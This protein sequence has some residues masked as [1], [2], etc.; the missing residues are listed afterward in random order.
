[1]SKINLPLGPLIVDIATT[2]LLAEDKEILSH[3]LV[4]GV[5]LFTRNFDNKEQ[6]THLVSQ[7][8]SL[9]NPELLIC[10][11]QEGGRVQ[12]FKN[13]FTELPPLHC[14]GNLY[15]QDKTA[16]LEASHSLAKLM[17]QELKPTGIDFSFAPVVDLYDASS[18]IIANRAFHESPNIIAELA[19]S[20]MH[21]LHD[22]GMI[23]VAKHFPGHGGTLEDSHLC[24]PQDS[25]CYGEVDSQD[26][27]PYKKLFNEGLDAVMT[28]HVLFNRIDALPSGFSS[29]WLKD[30]LREQLGFQGI[31][32]TDDLS[33][34]GAIELGNVVDRTYMALEAGC[35]IALIC[36]DR[37]SVEQVLQ[38]NELVNQINPH[39]ALDKLCRRI[40][41]HGA[42]LS[43]T[44][45]SELLNTLTKYV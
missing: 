23:A 2:S 18:Q 12:R 30:I 32:F 27:T 1:M 42:P 15:D 31:V 8:K 45:L 29:F 3:P 19:V 10:I 33:M 36:N 20:Y 6:V 39:A 41:R 17:A 13:G 14:L 9:R 11:D 7:I 44:Q 28:A 43:K 38:D 24:L 35:D 21:G 22:M 34:Q 5:I 26:L 4:G 16:A 37:L 25:R 40:D